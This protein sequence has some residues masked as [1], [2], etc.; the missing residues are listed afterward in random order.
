MKKLLTILFLLPV[1]VDATTRYVKVA[2]GTGAGTD[3]ATAW[4]YAKFNSTTLVAG[5]SVLFKRGDVF[6][7]AL[8]VSTT[9]TISNK[10]VYSCY[11]TGSKPVI[12]GFTTL[13]AWTSL[14]GGVW[15]SSCPSCKLTD[16]IV[17]RDGVV[18]K[19]GRYPNSGYLT[20]ESAVSNT[21]ITDNELTGT[22]NWTGGEVVIRKNNSI[23][24]RNAITS[25]SGST[26]NY[27]SGSAYPGTANFGYFIQNDSL[28]LDS[29][30]EWFLSPS[31]NMKMYFGAGNPSTYT[32]KT[33]IVDT[34][35]HLLSKAYITFASI[36]F[37]GANVFALYVGDAIGVTIK[38]C[39]INYSGRDGIFYGGL[40]TNLNISYDTI[41]HSNNNGISESNYLSSNEYI[42]YNLIKNSGTIAGMGMSGDG[43]YIGMYNISYRSVV[44]YNEVDSSGYIG[45]HFYGDSMRVRN[46]IVDYFC[47]LKYDGGGIYTYVG[48][49]S[50]TFV[51]TIV[52]DNTI[53]NAIGA[54]EGTTSLG[55]SNE[56]FYEADGIY[57]DVNSSQIT[58]SGN[59]ISNCVGSSIFL[60]QSHAITVSGNTLTNNHN[61]LLV[62]YNS[63]HPTHSITFTGNT[64]TKA[65]GANTF[66]F[67]DWENSP[68]NP[69]AID[70]NTYI[71]GYA[72]DLSFKYYNYSG[73]TANKTFTGWKTSMTGTSDLNSTLS[74]IFND[75]G[76]NIPR[77]VITQ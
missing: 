4:S 65:T 72:N 36:D 29:L 20:F 1:F 52:S 40:V 61:G 11:G 30:G 28:T 21:S 51:P 43:N 5:D 18:Q 12:S 59:T 41:N 8:T 35:V 3:D 67:F 32:I 16:N 6:Y 48:N 68:Y 63:G 31:K 77:K 70:N 13:S 45:I 75:S 76:I 66:V 15:Y 74:A 25:H 10:I 38:N 54:L 56:G 73:A 64:V 34:L 58:L 69:I 19:I 46:N 9:G 24:D 49:D 47:F 39:Y 44:E 2:G 17:T 7:G 22:P 57:L 33:S 42:G 37:E 53:S 26:I 60:M 14:G 55:Y 62:R 23:I 71:G 50:V 27:T